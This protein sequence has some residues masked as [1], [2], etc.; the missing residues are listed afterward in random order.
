MSVMVLEASSSWFGNY[1]SLTITESRVYNHSNISHA[2]QHQPKWWLMMVSN[3]KPKTA[4]QIVVAVITQG[5]KPF[6]V[7]EVDRCWAGK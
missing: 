4:A 7:W 5:A 6:S 2:S 1:K 3:P